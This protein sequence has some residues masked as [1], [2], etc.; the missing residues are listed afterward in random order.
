V[1]PFSEASDRVNPLVVLELRRG[2]RART[3]SAAFVLLLAGGAITALIAYA[4][5]DGRGG[6]VGSRSFFALYIGLAAMAFFVLPYGAFRSLSREREENTWPLLVLTGL[7]PRRI[8]AGKVGSTLL[9]AL[10]YASALAPFLLFSYLLQGVDLVTVALLIGVSAAFQ[11]F[12]TV[13]A[14]AAATL[15]ESRLWRGVVHL[16]V[17]GALFFATGFGVSVAGVV[18]EEAQRRGLDRDVLIAVGVAAGLMAS[19]GALFFA[20]AVSRLT[21]ASDNWALWPRLALLAQLALAG[22]GFALA[23]ADR[24]SA[25]TWTALAV[26]AAVHASFAALIGGTSAPGLS[27]RVRSSPSFGR[28]LLAPGAA[29]SLRFHVLLMLLYGLLAAAG[30]RALGA[31]ERHWHVVAAAY[32]FALLYL[33]TPVALGRGPL[34]RWLCSPGHLR[35]F[36]LLFAVAGTGLPMLAAAIAGR[37]ADDAAFNRLNPGVV[38]ARLDRKPNG[39][40]LILLGALALAAALV[41]HQVALSRDRE[42]RGG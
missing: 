16:M 31:S 14:A 6:R 32:L 29:S 17:L 1:R 26:L 7:G 24:M 3:F 23:W 37:E 12:L 20:V 2:L 41:A 34:R 22:V 9:Q 30:L 39:E 33:C 21:F 15:A 11:V 4:S 42:A 28:G 35:A 38:L 10:L 19:Y 27:L 40:T 13:A 25:S 8:L 5:Y 36:V 18:L